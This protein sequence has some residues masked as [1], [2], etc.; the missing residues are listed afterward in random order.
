MPLIL[1]HITIY[2]DNNI[3]HVGFRE[4]G[5]RRQAGDD[6]STPGWLADAR[7]IGKVA[8]ESQPRIIIIIIA[9]PDSPS[10]PLRSPV[11]RPIHTSAWRHGRCQSAG[12]SSDVASKAKNRAALSVIPDGVLWIE[13]RPKKRLPRDPGAS[14]HTQNKPQAV[15]R[16]CVAAFQQPPALLLLCY[17]LLVPDRLVR[18]LKRQEQPHDPFQLI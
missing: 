10:P 5:G 1:G 9:L 13:T 6:G 17:A 11:K 3:T 12:Q 7:T 16:R 14:T 4:A 18:S 8:R 15:G 2:H